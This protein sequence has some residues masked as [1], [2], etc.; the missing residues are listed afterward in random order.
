MEKKL[1]WQC[2]MVGAVLFM[3]SGFTLSLWALDT[4]YT[5]MVYI[6]LAIIA[7]VCV[8]WWFWVMIVIKTIMG[9]TERTSTNIGTIKDEIG[10]IKSIVKSIV[11]REKDK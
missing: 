1:K 5:S 11:T 9:T 2:V 7:T 4:G 10:K 3:V 6:G 8:S